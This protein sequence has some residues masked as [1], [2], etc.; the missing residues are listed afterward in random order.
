[1]LRP[2]PRR[3]RSADGLHPDVAP[4]LRFMR[5]HR[6]SA[7]ADRTGQPP[8]AGQL[9]HVLVVVFS[10]AQR[11]PHTDV[12]APSGLTES[13]GLS[14]VTYSHHPS[15]TSGAVTNT[16]SCVAW[17]HT[18]CSATVVANPAARNR[19]NA[20]VTCSGVDASTPRW[21]SRST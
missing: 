1:M 6:L 15:G 5:L 14:S 12:D 8:R 4:Q 2:H 21:L 17:Q 16:L 13:A 10:A 18:S 3:A 11:A 9:Q 7:V 19:P 20:A